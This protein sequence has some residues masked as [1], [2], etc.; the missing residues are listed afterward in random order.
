M[1]CILKPDAPEQMYATLQA[2]LRKQKKSLP[3]VY[4]ARKKTVRQAR[5]GINPSRCP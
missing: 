3:R 2:A 4:L 1:R 5:N